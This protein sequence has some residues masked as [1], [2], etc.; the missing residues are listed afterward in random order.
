MDNHE[1]LEVSQE[2]QLLIF[3]IPFIFATRD[4]VADCA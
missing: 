4:A 3:E 2:Q 1:D